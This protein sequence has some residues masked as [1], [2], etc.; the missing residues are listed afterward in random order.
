M[1]LPIPVL[2]DRTFAQLV[3]EA[4]QLIPVYAPQWTDHNLSDPGM[5]LVELLAWLAEMQLY[6]LD[7]VSEP[8]L[9]KY[10]ALLGESP[11]PASPARVELQL[12]PTANSCV[13]V[14]EGTPFTS[15][16]TF[17]SEGDILA[18]PIQ[19][20]QV[21]SYANYRFTEVTEFNDHPHT[22]Y[23][24][25]G[26]SPREGDALYLGLSSEA[27]LDYLAGKE[28][29]FAVYVYEDDLPPVGRGL[30]GEEEV[31]A[32][33]S[34]AVEVAWEYWNGH[35]WHPLTM[36]ASPAAAAI[37]SGRGFLSFVLPGDIVKEIPP[38]FPSYLE[39][40]YALWWFRCRLTRAGYEIAPRLDRLL[41]NV[42]AAAEGETVEEVWTGSGLPH[43]VFKTG[44]CPVVPASQIVKIEG[45]R[46]QAVPDFDASLP[47]DRH[48]V[49]KPEIGEIRFGSGMNGA[50]PPEGEAIAVRYRRGGGMGGNIGADTIRESGITGVT[51]TN[52]FPAYGGEDGE[53]IQ[54]AF[55]RCK[56]ELRIPYTAVTADDYEY[57][58]RATPG[59]RVARARAVILNDT[60]EVAMVVIPYSFSDR[61]LP[62]EPFKQAVCRYLEGHRLLTTA[63]KVCDPDYVT[64]SISAEIKV[65]S[66]YHPDQIRQRIHET[67]SHFLSPLKRQAGD[68]E[69]PFGR[70]VYRSEISEELEGVEGV[71]CVPDL[72]LSAAGGSFKMREGNIEIGPLSLVCSGTIQVKM[73][74]PQV[75]CQN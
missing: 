23:H 47:G 61:P 28:V 41:P 75:K 1:A 14:P 2:D 44:G 56:R 70:P 9:L 45:E 36:T 4:R 49:V 3:E 13:P 32:S 53:S 5:T 26:T 25:F 58:A 15:E 64:V 8:H 24:G 16:F 67:L 7:V 71:D 55:A 37:L 59:L 52:P 29:R 42:V 54:E 22:Y 72:S 33:V 19:L 21:V 39:G 20:Q 74:D 60:N 10:L 6:S 17:E 68:N 65:K 46:W 51:V 34:P 63:I 38:Q 31:T 73:I 11:R 27:R 43:Q 18:V 40:D 62:G 12:T 57:I 30:P 35:Q 48:Y 50:V 66:G 69:W